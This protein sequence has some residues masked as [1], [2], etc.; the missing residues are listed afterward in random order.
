M[1][2]ETVVGG[3]MIFRLAPCND[4]IGLCK[5][6]LPTRT[7]VLSDVFGRPDPFFLHK[8]PSSLSFLC[9]V[10]I[11]IAVG[12]CFKNSITNA[13]CTVLFDCDR[14]CSNTQNPFSLPVKGVSISV[15][16]KHKIL[17]CLKTC[18]QNEKKFERE[19]A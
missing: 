19:F 8:R 17:T 11:Y 15:W 12:D 1:M 18:I 10:Q 7:T 5:F 13:C 3:I 14:V 16:I 6:F 2:R 4:F 9:H